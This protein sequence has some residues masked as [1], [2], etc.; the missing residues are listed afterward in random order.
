M[1]QA[2][3]TAQRLKDQNPEFSPIVTPKGFNRVLANRDARI[4]GFIRQAPRIGTD[5][6]TGIDESPWYTHAALQP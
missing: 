4:C 3:N 2:R 5:S 6:A 1:L